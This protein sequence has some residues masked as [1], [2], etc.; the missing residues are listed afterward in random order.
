MDSMPSGQASIGYDLSQLWISIFTSVINEKE[1]A[2]LQCFNTAAQFELLKRREVAMAESLPA[3]QP[4]FEDEGRSLTYCGNQSCPGRI[5]WVCM[6]EDTELDKF[7]FDSFL[8]DKPD[9]S[10]EDQFS[11]PKDEAQSH[12]A[13][14]VED[15]KTSGD[16]ICFWGDRLAH[17]DFDSW[18]NPDAKLFGFDRS[19]VYFGPQQDLESEDFRGQ[20]M[21][22]YEGCSILS[23]PLAYLYS[24]LAHF[25]HDFR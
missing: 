19:E 24:R 25:I 15:C 22:T 2:Y 10:L 11:A 6:C 4:A 12:E 21:I 20:P 1:I 23:D 9:L 18:L 14:E 5:R 17:F 3:Q 7:D 8:N 16:R 13:P